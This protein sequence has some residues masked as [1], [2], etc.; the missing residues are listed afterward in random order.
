MMILAFLVS[1]KPLKPFF[2]GLFIL[3][4]SYSGG[5]FLNI[6]ILI[7]FFLIG[8]IKYKGYRFKKINIFKSAIIITLISVVFIYKR[9]EIYNLMYPILGRIDTIFDINKHS[10]MFIMIM[11]FLWVLEGNVINALFGYG[12]NSYS[13]LSLTKFLPNGNRVHT[14]SN[15][16]YSDTIFELGYVGFS[17]YIWMFIRLI[18]TS[19]KNIYNNKNFFI[20]MLLSV[21]LAASSIYRADFMQSRFWILLFI[22][23]KLI[24]NGMDKQ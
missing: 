8:Y 19:F 16:F 23:V 13:Y 7:P 11:P 1:K 14:T 5:G 3:I 17:V 15:S 20:S 22:I 18:F 24:N 10:R 12:P 6:L 2:L 9:D 4:F 21:H